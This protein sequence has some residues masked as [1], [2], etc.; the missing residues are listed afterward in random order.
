MCRTLWER[1]IIK[2]RSYSLEVQCTVCETGH[3]SKW[4]C[5]RVKP[6]WRD[7]RSLIS[8]IKITDWLEA[9]YK[10]KGNSNI[11]WKE[12]IKRFFFLELAVS[13]PLFNVRLIKILFAKAKFLKI[14]LILLS[15]SSPYRVSIPFY[16]SN[17]NCLSHTSEYIYVTQM[18][19]LTKISKSMGILPQNSRLTRNHTMSLISC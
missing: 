8:Y 3:I 2:Y 18:N 9:R 15:H 6:K 5:N 12:D 11:L 14:S 10:K 19:I 4:R 7:I 17:G 13:K 16:F 1:K